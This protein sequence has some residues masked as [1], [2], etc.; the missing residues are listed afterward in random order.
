[1]ASVLADPGFA[2]V[3]EGEWEAAAERALRGEPLA[4]LVATLLDGIETSPLYT[5]YRHGTDD[6]PAGM[7][8]EAPYRRGTSASAGGIGWEVRQTHDVRLV[9]TPDAVAVDTTSGVDAVTVARGWHAEDDAA[10]LEAGIGDA[11]EAGVTVH[12]QAGAS[13]EHA[14]ALL[15]LLERRGVAEEQAQSW[16]GIDPVAASASGWPASTGDGAADGLVSALEAAALSAAEI[17]ERWPNVVPLEADGSVFADAGAIDTT[18]LAAMLAVGVAWLRVLCDAPAG[19]SLTPDAAA[20]RIGFTMSAGPDP[21]VVTA[22]CRALRLCWARVLDAAGSSAA[23]EPEDTEQAG[24]NERAGNSRSTG[25][26]ASDD[27]AP[28]LPMR[29]HA[30]TSTAMLSR[31]DRWVNMLRA[32][33]A[34]FGAANGGAGA[35]TV[36]P[37]DSIGNDSARDGTASTALGWRVA[38][39][40]QLILRDESRVGSVIDPAGGSWYLEDLTQSMAAA[41]WTGFQQ[42]EAAGGICAVLADGQIEATIAAE[43]AR[44]HEQLESGDS[45][46][47]GVTQFVPPAE[48]PSTVPVESVPAP[49]ADS[50]A[51]GGGLGIHRW[52]AP[53]E[54]GAVQR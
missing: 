28:A 51:S 50:A 35:I 41:A 13:P 38:A 47:V 3:S 1:M 46:L 17:A 18:E 7:P 45:V 22:K 43:R 52:A 19:P 15:D 9:G 10:A 33:A 5:P 29:L 53:F 24:R 26:G 2:E 23:A 39:N 36:L 49:D 54:D 42:I 37:F 12:L 8:G 20:Q 21:F 16:L 40:T 30:V 14:Q 32:T 31:Q 48:A 34:T 44:R 25:R 27:A 6:D 4:S 11:A